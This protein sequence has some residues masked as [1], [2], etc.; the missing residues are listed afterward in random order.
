MRLTLWLER[1]CDKEDCAALTPLALKLRELIKK[2]HSKLREFGSV[3]DFTLG[4]V[5]GSSS[6]IW[7]ATQNI[8]KTY[9]AF[10]KM[11]TAYVPAGSADGTVLKT[12]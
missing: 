2:T 6:L 4:I 8:N 11:Q 10:G 9:T 3:V 5:G 12:A 7:S 1:H